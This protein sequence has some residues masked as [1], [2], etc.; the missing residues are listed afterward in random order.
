MLKRFLTSCSVGLMIFPTAS[1]LAETKPATK[2]EAMTES[3]ASVSNILIGQL[4]NSVE[5]ASIDF[6]FAGSFDSDK[7]LVMDSLNLSGIMKFN[8]D[9]KVDL[10]AK[11]KDGAQ[12]KKVLPV[13]QMDAKKLVA[14]TNI[15]QMNDIT[16]IS[17]DF[18]DHYDKKTS[19]WVPRPLTVSVSNEFN[20]S[21]C[22]IK[23]NWIV[24]KI[25]K[26]KDSKVS[27]IKGTCSSEKKLFDFVA[28]RNR[29][30]PVQCEFSGT[31]SDQ[32]YNIDFK[33]ENTP[34]SM[35]P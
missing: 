25:T 16:T 5:K 34:A 3:E 18:Y 15:S 8:D 26:S 29:I 23:F 6:E 7:G 10:G 13:I 20:T 32:G 33:Y 14:S 17:L 4:L 12:I 1:A 2:S 28:N 30:V 21:L 31:Y 24:A 11:K 19:A 9:W 35:K 22:T 27:R